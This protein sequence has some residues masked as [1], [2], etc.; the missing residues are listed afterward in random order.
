MN[1][2]G[3]FIIAEAG[4]NHDGDFN[5][6]LG[7]IDAAADA[8]ADC[9]KFQTFRAGE[10]VSAGTPK[11]AYQQITTAADESQHAMLKRLELPPAWHAKL[12]ERCRRRGVQFLST[13]FDLLSLAFLAEDL[14][15]DLIKLGSGEL[16]NAPLL[17]AAGLGGKKLIVST[18][19]GTL[20]ETRAALG[21]IACGALGWPPG[22]DAFEAALASAEGRRALTQRVTLLHCV[23][24]YPSPVEDTNLRALATLKS[25]F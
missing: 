22:S 5:R 18:G 16:T 4:V 19:M 21:A 24:D 14:N 2:T 8:G 23:T 11:A 1:E 12:I 9:V 10:L 13:P 25:A 6:A 20:E 7:L 3:I 17:Y 15:L